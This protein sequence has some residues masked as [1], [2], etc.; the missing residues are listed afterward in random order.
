MK[1]I[2]ERLLFSKRAVAF[3]TAFSA[4]AVLLFYSVRYGFVFVDNVLYTG[5]SLGLF[6]FACIGSACLFMI[7]VAKAHKK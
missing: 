5:F 1:K 4:V 7:F 2:L 3:F 6:A